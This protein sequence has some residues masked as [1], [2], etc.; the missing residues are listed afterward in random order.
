MSQEPTFEQ[1]M[2]EEI[3]FL[4]G[5]LYNPNV[6]S[7]VKELLNDVLLGA[8]TELYSCGCEDH[9]EDEEEDEDFGTEA[10]QPAGSYTYSYDP[11]NGTT[12]TT[13]SIGG[14]LVVSPNTH[15]YKIELKDLKEL[16]GEIF[17]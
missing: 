3:Q 11:E 7:E 13:A 1:C 5:L 10:A 4:G 9:D 14:P 16:L 12:T 15:V 2:K 6:S 8:L 17:K